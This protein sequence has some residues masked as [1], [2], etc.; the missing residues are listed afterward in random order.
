MVKESR[1]KVAV[2]SRAWFIRM[3][4]G[5]KVSRLLPMVPT[6]LT[7]W[8]PVV[9]VAVR[10]RM[11]SKSAHWSAVSTAPCPSVSTSSQSWVFQS[12]E[13]E[14][15]E[16]RVKVVLVPEPV[17]GT[18]PVPVQ[19]VATNWVAPLTTGELVT[20]AVTTVSWS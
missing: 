8:Y 11:V 2:R 20:A 6:H 14:E 12:Q 1:A 9:G 17:A 5:L 10:V 16:V 13:R 3:A 4:S 18:S 19:P 7:K 15:G